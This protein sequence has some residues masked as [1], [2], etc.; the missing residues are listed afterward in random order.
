MVKP[1][2]E[3]KKKIQYK[4]LE[5]FF[6]YPTSYKKQNKTKKKIKKKTEN[7]EYKFTKKLYTPQK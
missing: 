6:V 5:C 3:N 2:S 1:P 7:P 4:M